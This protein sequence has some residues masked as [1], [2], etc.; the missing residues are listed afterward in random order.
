MARIT[1]TNFAIL[2]GNEHSGSD[3]DAL[4]AVAVVGRVN[5]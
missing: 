3:V 1:L 5:Y 4:D 2:A